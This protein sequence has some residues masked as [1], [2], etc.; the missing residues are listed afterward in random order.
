MTGILIIAHA[1]LA[2]ALERCVEHVYS[3]EPGMTR[4]NLRVL[5]VEPGATMD[6]MLVRAQALR[7]EVDS[8]AGVL[9]LTDVFG[10]TPGNVAARLNEP[11]RV[12]VLAGVNL[13][14]LL[15]AVCYRG[16][17][18]ADVAAKALAGGQQG[19]VQ[20]ASTPMQ[21]QANRPQAM[22][23]RDFTISNKLGLHARPSA[24]IT[25]VASR[26][27]AEVWLARNGR[28]VNAKSIMGVMMLAAG[29]GSVL[30]V[31]AD[32]DDAAEVVDAIG[33]L[34]ETRFGEHE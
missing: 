10:A 25:Q 19:M 23:T 1:P 6:E 34:I 31:E 33:Q 17:T 29:Q 2:S 26:Y 3:C 18:L 20:V 8:G 24:Q 16:E 7:Q 4:A 27:S 28:R 12:A 13:P 5:D 21:N 22:I 30:T 11:G 32:G 9:V 15:R 14:M